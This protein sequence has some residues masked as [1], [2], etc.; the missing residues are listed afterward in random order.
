[1]NSDGDRA[2]KVAEQAIL[3]AAGLA[4]LA[5]D[6]AVSAAKS[7]FSIMRRRDLREMV[8]EGHDDLV[9]RG[10]LALNRHVQTPVPHMELLARH[11][12]AQHRGGDA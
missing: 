1:M 2:T 6:N 5:L 9:T 7:V 8:T 12:V 11:A 4:E 3:L 10:E